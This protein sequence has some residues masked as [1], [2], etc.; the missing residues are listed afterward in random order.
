MAVP[1]GHLSVLGSFLPALLLG[2]AFANIF[3]GLPIDA[4]GIFQG[5]L[6]TLL[7][8]YGLAG[9]VLFLLLFL[10]HGALWLAVKTDGDLQPGPRPWPGKFWWPLL[11]VAV[12]FLLATSPGHR[13]M[14]I[15]P[16]TRCSS[17]FRRWRWRP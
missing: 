16:P 7:N 6:L 4:E 13:S 11:V 9:G 8:P 17:S 10:V 3:Q 15:M 1:L 14:T 5:N 12:L 2:V